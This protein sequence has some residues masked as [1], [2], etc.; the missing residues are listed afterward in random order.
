MHAATICDAGGDD[1]LMYFFAQAVFLE[2]ARSAIP[3]LIPA[4]GNRSHFGRLVM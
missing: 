1:K 4:S 3:P 2:T